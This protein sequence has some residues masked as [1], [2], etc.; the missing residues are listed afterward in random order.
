MYYI[1]LPLTQ[2]LPGLSS[3]QSLSLSL[4][5][6]QNTKISRVDCC[7]NMDEAYS[8]CVEST[9]KGNNWNRSTYQGHNNRD[10]IRLR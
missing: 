6:Q 2:F 1:T 9:D 8:A 5:N 3:Y 4:T 10:L 7:L